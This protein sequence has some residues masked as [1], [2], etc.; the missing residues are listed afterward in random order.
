MVFRMSV[1]LQV[2]QPPLAADEGRRRNGHAARAERRLSEPVGTQEFG[3][4]GAV[5]MGA[6]LGYWWL[7]S[8]TSR[9][10]QQGESWGYPHRPMM[11]KTEHILCRRRADTQ[12][13]CAEPSHPQINDRPEPRRA[14]PTGRRERL[15]HARGFI[16][17]R[18]MARQDADQTRSQT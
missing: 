11:T 17:T 5:V 16:R 2:R 14:E 4:V 7:A 9:R 15:S 13:D 10:D 3:L 1:L 12:F 6:L 18:V 8:L